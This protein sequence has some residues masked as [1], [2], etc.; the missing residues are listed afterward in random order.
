MNMKICLLIVSNVVLLSSCSFA[1][2]VSQKPSVA[3]PTV[4]ARAKPLSQSQV[5]ANRKEFFKDV[6]ALQVFRKSKD[7]VLLTK[8]AERGRAKWA[9]RDR[10]LY[11]QWLSS[12]CDLLT[13]YDFGSDD[14]IILA[15][16]YSRE[17]L[18]NVKDLTVGLETGFVAN[19]MGD[20]D[21][22]PGIISDKEWETKR[23]EK[24]ELWLHATSRLEQAIDSNFDPNDR[25]NWP[26][27]NLMPP[28]GDGK[29]IITSGMSP[30]D[31]KDP[32]SRAQYKADIKANN[33][34]AEKMNDQV[35]LRGIEQY[36]FGFSEKY[37]VKIYSRKPYRLDELKSL[38]KRYNIEPKRQLVIVNAVTKSMQL[39]DDKS[40]EKRR[41]FSKSAAG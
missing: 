6:Q 35:G 29:Q 10:Q 40:P 34:K 21:A 4:V 14:N 12:V 28:I 36:F 25:K 13:S 26:F 31:V 38:L 11:L 27:A 9:N 1:Q 30:D 22:L 8:A 5:L 16:K 18:S 17:A 37:L 39:D 33:Q 24:A 41:V 19:L 7:L 15:E 2:P 23:K 20:T 3:A 32:K